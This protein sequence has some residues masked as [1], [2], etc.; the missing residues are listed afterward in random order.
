[1]VEMGTESVLFP[2]RIDDTT[3][4]LVKSAL[5]DDE[6]RTASRLR[7]KL[8]HWGMLTLSVHDARYLHEA[9]VTYANNEVREGSTTHK[10]ALHFAAALEDGYIGAEI[11][12]F[13]SKKE[14]EP[15]VIPEAKVAQLEKEHTD[16][17]R[18]EMLRQV[19]LGGP[20][21]KIDVWGNVVEDESPVSKHELRKRAKTLSNEDFRDTLRKDFEDKQRSSVNLSALLR[22]VSNLPLTDVEADK[23]LTGGSAL[24]YNEDM[25]IEGATLLL[26]QQQTSSPIGKLQNGGVVVGTVFGFRNRKR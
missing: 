6:S 9:L 8:A 18:D 24:N 5:C 11:R 17:L 2:I 23:V 4:P 14:S 21:K 1:M 7:K 26:E 10:K 19:F 22:S 25:K 12:A 13:S 15:I 3:V 20:R 16:Q